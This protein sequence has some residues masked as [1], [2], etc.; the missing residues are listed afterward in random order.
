MSYLIELQTAAGIPSYV[1][2]DGGSRE[3]ALAQ[4]EGQLAAADAEEKIVVLA[5]HT[6]H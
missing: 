4:V 2:A 6:V 1:I 3:E 5:V